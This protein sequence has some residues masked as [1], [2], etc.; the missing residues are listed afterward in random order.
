MSSRKVTASAKAA[1]NFA[2]MRGGSSCEH[3]VHWDAVRTV[4]ENTTLQQ[5][6]ALHHE[7]NFST[8][9]EILYSQLVP[10][11]DNN[12][13][14]A[15]RPWLASAQKNNAKGFAAIATVLHFELRH[16][17]VVDVLEDFEVVSVPAVGII[18]FLV[19]CVHC[20]LC[21]FQ[22]FRCW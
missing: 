14:E 5:L 21:G 17:P 13:A 12:G 8:F 9:S 6:R 7:D 15:P 19:L 16:R 22:G 2:S 1:G 3:R 4:I 10:G 18:L 20:F 11:T